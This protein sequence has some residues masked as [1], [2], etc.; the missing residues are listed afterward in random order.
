MS[1]ESDVEFRI[2]PI[3]FF[4]GGCP[5]TFKD[6]GLLFF[7]R[8]SRHTFFCWVSKIG[9]EGKFFFRVLT[10]PLYP[11]L[12]KSFWLDIHFKHSNKHVLYPVETIIKAKACHCKLHK[13]VFSIS[14]MNR[15]HGQETIINDQPAV[16]QKNR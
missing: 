11:K 7:V 16:F 13:I 9:S 14:K 10:I 8:T 2:D 3:L 1:Q 4:C 15:V 12:E 6:K 5:L